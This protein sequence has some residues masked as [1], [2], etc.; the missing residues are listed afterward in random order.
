[1]P[2]WASLTAGELAGRI[3]RKAAIWRRHFEAWTDVSA[4]FSHRN[5]AAQELSCLDRFVTNIGPTSE[6]LQ[7][8]GATPKRLG[9]ALTWKAARPK[10]TDP[11]W[12]ATHSCWESELRCALCDHVCQ[13]DRRQRRWQGVRI[14][15]EVAAQAIQRDQSLIDK[16]CAEVNQH[17]LLMARRLCLQGRADEA[18]LIAVRV[19]HWKVQTQHGDAATTRYRVMEQAIQEQEEQCATAG[20]LVQA[21]HYIV[22]DSKGQKTPILTRLLA[23]WK[24]RQLGQREPEVRVPSITQPTASE[25]HECLIAHWAGPFDWP[26][27]S[28]IMPQELESVLHSAPLSAALTAPGLTVS[29]A[30]RKVAREAYWICVE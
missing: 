28:D 19:P 29:R 3:G 1:M 15:C 6:S 2:Q 27:V 4:G 16:S 23:Q 24:R 20:E 11:A 10:N 30:I 25:Q 26:T 22:H 8:L 21:E 14:A 17:Y 12:V 5:Q 9:S 18:R 7:L 13:G